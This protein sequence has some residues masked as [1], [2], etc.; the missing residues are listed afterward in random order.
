M[1][2]L[3]FFRQLW[4][5]HRV[6]L[7][8][9]GLLLLVNLVLGLVLKLYLVP[10]VNARERQL[11]QLQGEL[12]GGGSGD[13]PAELFAQG[14]RDLA[15]FREKIP[16]YQEFTK[17]IVE[18]QE[19]ADEAGLDL[20]RISYEHKQGKDSDLLRYAL[21]FTLEGDYGSLK[22]FIHALEQL[23][24]LIVINEINLQGAGRSTDT[25]VRLQLS[26]ET[27]FRAGVP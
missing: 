3:D 22:Q 6:L 24:R 26:L 10:T 11:I 15:A 27:F 16:P 21:T 12:R 9:A 20:D 1:T 25:D 13:S 7:S 23:P 8:A 14:E 19:L 4:S 17:L 2:P 18:L 5:G